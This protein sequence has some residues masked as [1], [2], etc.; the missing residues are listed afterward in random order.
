VACCSGNSKKIVFR[1]KISEKNRAGAFYMAIR[2]ATHV[3]TFGTTGK[4][5]QIIAKMKQ[6][7]PEII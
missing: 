1:K 5:F 2:Y 6:A 3:Q 7:M 4:T